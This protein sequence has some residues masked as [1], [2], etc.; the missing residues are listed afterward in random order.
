MATY[1]TGWSGSK[2]NFGAVLSNKE[3]SQYFS[4]PI[5]TINSAISSI[6]TNYQISSITIYA[7]I[8]VENSAL[9]IY[10]CRVGYG[11]S[12]NIGTQLNSTS[13][14]TCMTWN[15]SISAS[16]N[17]A[18]S[19]NRLNASYGGGYITFHID[20]SAWGKKTYKI[21]NVYVDVSYYTLKY[22]ITVNASPDEGGT[23]S[24]S[25]TYD[26]GSYIGIRAEQNNQLYY[27]FVKW[28][29]GITENPR[30]ITVNGNATYTAIF[31][32]RKHTV[33]TQVIPEGAGTVIG[34]GVHIAGERVD[35][36][37][38]ANHGWVFDHWEILGNESWSREFPLLT[39]YP[40]SDI[41]YVAV[42]KIGRI[43]YILIDTAQTK[44]ILLNTAEADKIFADT[45]KVYG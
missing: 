31:E 32:K 44:L 38:I 3:A 8:N 19:G 42:F 10:T 36:E 39:T 2:A 45:T 27:Q 18:I 30:Y 25:G 37:A 35:L 23:V 7:T 33:A 22:T 34:G 21:S 14:G 29:D 9:G 5:S 20:T 40:T 15:G 24:G 41:T 12:G 4:M 13:S 11:G 16:L 26:A 43:N 28:S 17:A 6:S 1:Q